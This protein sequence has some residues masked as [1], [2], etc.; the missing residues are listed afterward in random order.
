MG[1]PVSAQDDLQFGFEI[2]GRAQTARELKA[3]V[4]AR[5]NEAEISFETEC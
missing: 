4:E 2:R 5:S 3:E 1:G